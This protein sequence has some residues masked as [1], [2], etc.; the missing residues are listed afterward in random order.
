[1]KK[2]LKTNHI[3]FFGTE[4]GPHLP[5]Q[6]YLNKLKFKGISCHVYIHVFS[7]YLDPKINSL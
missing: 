3:D 1:M 2:K 4:E 5:I 7:F 6:R